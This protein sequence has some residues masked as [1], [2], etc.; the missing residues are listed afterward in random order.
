MQRAD[1]R[2]AFV[3][4]RLGRCDAAQAP[5]PGERA[6]S[7]VKAYERSG[8]VDA[9]SGSIPCPQA[10]HCPLY[11]LMRPRGKADAHLEIFPLFLPGPRFTTGEKLVAELVP[12][13]PAVAFQRDVG[14]VPRRRKAG[15]QHYA[16]GHTD[17]VTATSHGVLRGTVC[18]TG[19]TPGAQTERRGDDRPM[20][21]C[22]TAVPHRPP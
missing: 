2:T 21:G 4:E 12:G 20:T 17:Q 14:F 3:R 19:A 10:R 6:G 11:P 18:G 8:E 22:L 1:A 7:V 15:R 16:Q 5:L 9:R 13:G